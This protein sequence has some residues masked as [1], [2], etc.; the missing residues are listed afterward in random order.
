MNRRDYEDFKVHPVWLEIAAQLKD[1][2]EVLE[3]KL[4]NCDK[5]EI[6]LVRMELKYAESLLDAPTVILGEINEEE[7]KNAGSNKTGSRTEG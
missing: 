4:R 5:D 3:Y 1:N 2:I 6:D 7:K